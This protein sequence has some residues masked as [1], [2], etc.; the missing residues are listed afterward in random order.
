MTVVQDIL[1]KMICRAWNLIDGSL[2][3]N[4]AAVLI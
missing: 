1:M 2:A 3:N 4:L